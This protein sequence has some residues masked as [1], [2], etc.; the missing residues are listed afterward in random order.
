MS[1]CINHR[2]GSDIALAEHK[3]HFLSNFMF[4]GETFDFIQFSFG[5]CEINVEQ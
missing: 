4:T 2:A 1:A 3:P 5:F